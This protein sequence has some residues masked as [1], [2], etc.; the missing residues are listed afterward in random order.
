M[1]R[2]RESFKTWLE[3]RVH[4]A[5]HQAVRLSLTKARS[6]LRRLV[7]H[8]LVRIDQDT[9]DMLRTRYDALLST[10]FANAQ[11]GAYPTR[12]LYETPLLGQ[13]GLIGRFVR[14]VFR[15]Q[16]RAAS[17][18]TAEFDELIDLSKYP[19]YFRCNFHWQTN[20]YLSD[21]SAE[22]YS[23][24][25]EFLFMG[26]ANVMR[27]QAIPPITRYLRRNKN[28][29]ARVLDVAC[30]TGELLQQLV[31]THP[32]L[33]FSGVDLSEPYLK[34]AARRHSHLSKVG[35]LCANAE[36][37]PYRDNYFDA[38]TCVYLMHELPHEVR[39]TVVAEMLR[40]L[41][42]G[43]LL[44]I[45]DSVQAG[46]VPQMDSLLKRY[47]QEANEPYFA[48]YLEDDLKLLLEGQGATFVGCGDAFVAKTITVRK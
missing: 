8:D 27:R 22:L 26:M 36:E 35:L 31:R 39:R 32:E 5:H 34:V 14:E 29:P 33:E 3:R 4:H 19:D 10:D 43:G 38:V 1:Y 9:K 47:A 42:P 18:Q 23:M 37:L 11:F 46:E 45:Q 44:I 7:N 48:D 6:A 12:F 24:S 16:K 21:S 28:Q 17:N 13:S 2:E 40:V 20:G 15:Q 41:K 30:G 25:V